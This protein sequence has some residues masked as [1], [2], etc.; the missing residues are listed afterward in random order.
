ML[1]GKRRRFLLTRMKKLPC[2]YNRLKDD[3]IV[4]IGSITIKAISTPGHTPGSMAY[5]INDTA[6]FTGDAI[7][8]SKGKA[9]TFSSVLNIEKKERENSI[10]KIAKLP[11]IHLLATAHYGYTKDFIE[12]MSQWNK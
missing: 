1:S 5:L 2:E 9:K 6:L 7:K 10:K 3:D 4:K 12:A 11:N 8:L